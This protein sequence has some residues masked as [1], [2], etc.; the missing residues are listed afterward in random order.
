MVETA[1][2]GCTSVGNSALQTEKT[3]TQIFSKSELTP[4]MVSWGHGLS[5][6]RT[7]WKKIFFYVGK[8]YD[9]SLLIF[10][11][12]QIPPGKTSRKDRNTNNDVYRPN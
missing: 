10:T 6:K 5:L 8:K 1:S 12:T 11:V 9:Q 3:V 4:V 2:R 7:I